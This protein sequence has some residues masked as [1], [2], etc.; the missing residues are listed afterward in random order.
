MTIASPPDELTILSQVLQ[1]AEQERR[2]LLAEQLAFPQRM[3]QTIQTGHRDQ[4]MSLQQRQDELPQQI[5]TARVNV[6]QLQLRL[7]DIEHHAAEETQ[8]QLQQVAAGM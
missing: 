2:A 8:R 5:A 7:L 1:A 3:P 4:I 6:L